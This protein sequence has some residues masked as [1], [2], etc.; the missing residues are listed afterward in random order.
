MF[1]K[2]SKLRAMLGMLHA[3]GFG[4]FRNAATR[5]GCKSAK[6]GGSSYGQGRQSRTQIGPSNEKRGTWPRFFAPIVA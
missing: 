6:H 2:L 5:I 4:H 1:D 3:D